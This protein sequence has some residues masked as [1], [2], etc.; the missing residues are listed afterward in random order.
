MR[1]ALALIGIAIASP[2]HATSSSGGTEGDLFESAI[3]C[4][5][6]LT[7]AADFLQGWKPQAVDQIY[8]VAST[9]AAFREYAGSHLPTPRTNDQAAYDLE[10]AMLRGA[11]YDG[12]QVKQLNA[13]K[14]LQ[15][16]F[17]ECMTTGTEIDRL[18]HAQRGGK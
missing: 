13:F 16:E 11:D 18:Q 5:A 1:K 10:L 4:A 8:K 2:G 17:G 9:S 7:V 14:P 12:S 3:H 15:G 6:V